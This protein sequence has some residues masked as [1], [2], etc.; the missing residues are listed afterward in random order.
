V[1]GV[2]VRS[3]MTRLNQ[4]PP[5]VTGFWPRDISVFERYGNLSSIRVSSRFR[6][7]LPLHAKLPVDRRPRPEET[8]P[9]KPAR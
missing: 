9:K 3:S 7:G 4:K 2:E 8:R 1:N 5:T 6:L